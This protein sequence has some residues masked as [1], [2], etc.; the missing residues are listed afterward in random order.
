MLSRVL[1]GVLL[2]G[3]LAWAV[4]LWAAWQFRGVA[5]GLAEQVAQG[6]APAGARDD[7]P[8]P[9]AAFARRG[10]AGTEP[11]GR[12][13]RLT[14]AAEMELTPGAGWQPLEARQAIGLTAPG[15]VW[16]A[17]QSLGPVVTLRVVDAY[18][19]GQGLL[20]ARVMGSLRV[21]R[22]EGGE[23]DR[24]GHFAAWEQPDAFVAEL[25]TAFAAMR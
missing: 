25:R 13:V 6:P 21:A 10:M 1:I 3:V 7:L 15:F 20:E 4:H 16:E 12:V 19:A 11:G 9:I 2:V 8:G 5:R 24:G 17:W 22:V 14:Q 18:V 23:M